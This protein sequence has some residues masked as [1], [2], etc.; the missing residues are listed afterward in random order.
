MWSDD[1]QKSY[2]YSEPLRAEEQRLLTPD[3]L[4]ARPRALISL[5]LLRMG[6]FEPESE[7]AQRVPDAKLCPDVRVCPEGELCLYVA[8][9][10]Q[11]CSAHGLCHHGHLDGLEIVFVDGAVMGP[12][13]P[14][15]QP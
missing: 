9:N 13:Y 3:H 2:G 6:G 14:P 1:H 5:D 12:G 7:T 11:R 8:L 10:Y 4:Y 15:H